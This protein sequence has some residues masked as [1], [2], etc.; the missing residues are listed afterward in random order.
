M[1][2]AD[3]YDVSEARVLPYTVVDPRLQQPHPVRALDAA[4]SYLNV[5]VAH[6]VGFRPLRVDIH[7]PELGEGPFPVV[8]YAH[9]GGFVGG[10]KEIGP[11]SALPGQGIAV[12]SVEYR[13]AGEAR[14]PAAIR[15]IETVLC[16]LV[17]AADD[18]G[19]DADNI[20][21]WGSSAGAYLAG[22]AML[23][24]AA[25]ESAELTSARARV[26]GVV[27]HYPPVDFG[28]MLAQW[29]DRPD[30]AGRLRSSMRA[31]F[32][33]DY[34]VSEE[35]PARTS[36]S[37]AVA[38]ACVLPPFHVAHG[39]AD[40]V[41]PVSQ[42]VLLCDA[43]RRRG[44]R[45]GLQVVSGEEHATAA[46][47]SWEVVQPAVEFLRSVWTMPRAGSRSCDRPVGT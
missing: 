46:F 38:E 29:R 22:G 28:H 13:L 35:V 3:V 23:G 27:L 6:D 34:A 24:I 25:T 26:Q 41:V 33:V 10:V 40:T 47:S 44:V 9:G 5:S 7:V 1:R 39:D 30:L 37:R 31:L 8:L 45:A 17:A 15:D 14:F 20:A 43:L 36:L 12:V 19:L 32:G 18:F 16:W 4:T 21:L 2:A 42:S 11:W